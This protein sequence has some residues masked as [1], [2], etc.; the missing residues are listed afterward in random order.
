MSDIRHDVKDRRDSP[1]FDVPL[2]IRHDDGSFDK[3]YGALSLGGCDYE[4]TQ[5]YQVGQKISLRIF[6]V[7]MRRN[8]VVV[9]SVVR[10][11]SSHPSGTFRVAV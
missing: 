5:E 7:G 2:F 4:S 8:L 9:G 10:V 11:S 6:L 3:R 1:R